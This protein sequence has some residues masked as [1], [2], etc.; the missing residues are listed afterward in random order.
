[1][2][3]S[4]VGVIVLV[5]CAMV[6][7]AC[8]GGNSGASAHST[9]T[10]STEVTTTTAPPTHNVKALLLLGPCDVAGMFFQV[11]PGTQATLTDGQGTTLGVSPVLPMGHDPSRP[12]WCGAPFFFLNVPETDFYRL[13]MSGGMQTVTYSLSDMQSK[14]WYITTTMD[15]LGLR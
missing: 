15:Q 6:L 10:T 14:N 5:V 9:T 8:G 12:G 7:A 13:T 4:A 2:A 3:R 1:M 11:P